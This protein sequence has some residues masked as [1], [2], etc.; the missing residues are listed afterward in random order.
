MAELITVAPSVL[1]PYRGV[2]TLVTGASGFI[3]RWIARLL[4]EAGS[5]LVLASRDP[6]AL[7]SV[8]D[9]LEING[10]A[11]P[12]DLG[13]EAA[14]DA[15]V[16]RVRPAV[17]FHLAGYGVDRAETDEREARRINAL[18]VGF[19]ADAVAR[20]RSRNWPGPQLVHAGSAQEYGIAGGNLD[21]GG[22]ALPTTV[23][24]KTK[25]EGTDL[26]LDRGKHP[27]L[28]ALIVRLFTVYGP[29]E[30]AGRLLP[31]LVLAAHT[32]EL[33]PLTAGTHRRDFTYVG[34]VAEGLLRLGVCEAP[35]RC[36]VNLA[37]G[38]LTSV[39]EFVEI[40]APILGLPP[41]RLRFGALP[42][43]GDEMEHDAV[44]LSRLRQLTGGWHP[45]TSIS[46]GV[47]STVAHQSRG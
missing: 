37:T 2:R 8:I 22:P 36:I 10:E 31:S 17:T 41:E 34:D 18:A 21:E 5:A 7:R 35:G 20:W 40:A 26:L 9:Q 1:A 29:G 3:G 25:L 42:T 32:G 39:R 44:S 4:S 15:L 47:R 19:I 23:Y 46:E 14:V 43:R 11:V 6:R 38:R 27:S 30:R 24:G 33:M 13:D 12:V 45:G 28:R 16:R